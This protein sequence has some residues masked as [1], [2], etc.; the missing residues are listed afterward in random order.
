MTTM[1]NLKYLL[2]MFY[3]SIEHEYTVVMSYDNHGQSEVL[4]ENVLFKH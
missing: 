1:I 4:G 3:S 2:K